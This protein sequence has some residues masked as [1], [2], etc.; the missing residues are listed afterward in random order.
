MREV[1]DADFDVVEPAYRP[2]RIHWFSTLYAL[3]FY[4]GCVAAVVTLDDPVTRACAVVGAIT[5]APLMRLFGSVAQQ[6]S[7][8]E[9]HQLRQRLSTREPNVW[10][11]WGSRRSRAE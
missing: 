6:V 1:I 5:Y 7:E 2:P 8:Q 4:F 10:E 3:V 11:V 9:A